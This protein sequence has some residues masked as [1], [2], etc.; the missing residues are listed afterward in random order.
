MLPIVYS[1]ISVVCW[2][3]SDFTGGYASKRS[4]AFLITLCAHLSGSAL[5]LTS[6]LVTHA[7]VPDRA[8]QLWA[9][10]AGTMGGTALAIFYRTL[11]GGKMGLTAPVAALIGAAI[12]T[13]FGMM[14][15][16]IPGK[17]PIVGF[18]LAAAGI[19]LISRPEERPPILSNCR[20]RTADDG[21]LAGDGKRPEGI[22]TA[23]LCGVGFA[24]FMLSINQVGN[25]S[26]VW[27]A[28]YSRSASL[29]VVGLIVL[30]R[31]QPIRL[32]RRGALLALLAG[33]IDVTGTA[34]F[35]R[36]D[37]TGRLD[38]AVVITSLYPAVTVILARLILKEHFHRWRA[39][40]ILA[41]LVAVPLIALQ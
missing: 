25:S 23:V 33:A 32:D 14:T 15:E 27:S 35:I 40:G 37:Q 24:G 5:M 10:L 18:L 20:P 8:S 6:A 28:A 31:R 3:T 22:A 36:A 26:V 12:P 30:A 19:W 38:S 11:A 4:D 7:P 9:L 21:V 17:L 16:G 34:L 39:L 41:S 29:V 2:G 1:L 13:A